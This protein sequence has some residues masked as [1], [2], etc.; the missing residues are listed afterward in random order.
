MLPGSVVQWTAY[1]KIIF[2]EGGARFCSWPNVA[3]PTLTTAMG[4]RCATLQTTSLVQWCSGYHTPYPYHGSTGQ[5]I[6]IGGNYV[7]FFIDLSHSNQTITSKIICKA[8]MW[9]SY[10]HRRRN[11]CSIS[12]MLRVSKKALLLGRVPNLFTTLIRVKWEL[13]HGHVNTGS[14][15]KLIG[16]WSYKQSSDTLAYVSLL[17]NNHQR[18]YRSRDLPLLIINWHSNFKLRIFPTTML[19][20]R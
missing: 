17:K 19:I 7:A 2:G 8:F 20:L 18:W 3:A 13:P 1:P 5:R 14:S 16:K 10:S 12:E 15:V 6:E 9:V 4:F 11:N